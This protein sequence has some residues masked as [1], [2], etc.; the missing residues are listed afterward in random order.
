MSKQMFE[1]HR[2]NEIIDVKIEI[3][4]LLS[5]FGKRY[6]TAHVYS[7]RAHDL[8]LHVVRDICCQSLTSIYIFVH[9][10]K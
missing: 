3:I 1:I 7:L 2:R 8:S 10:I 5:V 9:A 6:K 4:P